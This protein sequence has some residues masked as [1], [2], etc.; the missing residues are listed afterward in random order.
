LKLGYGFVHI[1]F[2]INKYLLNLL[3]VITIKIIILIRREESIEHQCK[4]KVNKENVACPIKEFFLSLKVDTQHPEVF[5]FFK[6]KKNKAQKAPF[7][8]FKLLKQI[9][10]DNTT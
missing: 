9:I 8:T 3:T 4:Q 10:T 6:Y 1:Y 2:Y 7:L 5:C